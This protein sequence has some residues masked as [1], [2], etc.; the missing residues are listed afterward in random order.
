M[1]L[2]K[3]TLSWIFAV[4][5]FGLFQL[6]AVSAGT[7]D[8][9]LNYAEPIG[10]PGTDP[11]IIIARIIQI[12]L[13]FLGILA[14]S[15]IIY[16]GF[17]WMTSKGDEEK[18]S[19]AKTIL[20]NGVI[21]LVIIL[22]S[23]AIATFVLS[24]LMAAFGSGGSGSGGPGAGGGLGALGNGIIESV[25]PEPGALGVPRNTS[26]IVTFRLPMSPGSIC[27]N[28]ENDLCSPG[29]KIRT[30]SVQI[31]NTTDPNNPSEALSNVLVSSN[32]NRTFVF[33]PVEPL[34]GSQ[35]TIYT[36]MLTNEIK[37]AANQGAFGGL[38]NFSWSFEVSNEFDFMPPRIL[39]LKL[40]DNNPPI[41]ESLGIFPL[42]DN[43]RDEIS[44]EI[45]PTRAFG[46]IEA[47]N[48]TMVPDTYQAASAT[49]ERGVG[50]EPGTVGASVSGTNQCENGEVTVLI[51]TNGT[52]A[53]IS[54]T[55]PGQEGDSLLILD[56]SVPLGPCDLMVQ[57]QSG[58][59]V[60]GRS[61]IVT[62]VEERQADTLTVG[63][64]I[65]TFVNENAGNFQIQVG[66]NAQQTAVAIRDKINS[67]SN[68]HP[69]VSAALDPR[70]QTPTVIIT[71]KIAGP[72][73][74][75]L[76]LSDS[77]IA[78]ITNGMRGG[79]ERQVNYTIRGERDQPMNTIIQINFNEAINPITVAGN[80]EQL[81]N[82]LRVINA[83]SEEAFDGASC[84]MD[85]ECRSFNC[86]EGSCRGDVLSG[87]FVIA[88]QYK[89]VEFISD[90][91]C[92]VNGCGESIYCLPKDAEV[93]VE[94]EAAELY[95]CTDSSQCDQFSYTQCVNSLCQDPG[96]GQNPPR[97]NP[98]ASIINGIVD[99][100]SNSFDGN[101]NMDAE[102]RRSY[103][104]QND[105]E[106]LNRGKGDHYNWSFWVSDRLDLTPP[107]IDSV[108]VVNNQPKVHLS[109]PIKI[110]FSKLMMSSTM[111][112]GIRMVDT[113]FEQVAHRLINLWSAG[114]HL[115]GYW[116][117]SQNIDSNSSGE[118][119]KTE[120]FLEHGFFRDST[121]YNSQVGSGVKD[122]YQNCY[123]PSSGPGC[124]ATAQNPSCCRDGNGNLLA[125]A[126]L[127]ADG[128]CPIVSN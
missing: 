24:R 128:K 41:N 29:T 60:A 69:Q 61:W 94:A 13:G 47:V 17:L 91:K 96:V 110:T 105:D 100:A 113:G 86:F 88:N 32:D 11:R 3:V 81:K 124:I 68:P 117:R 82:K 35:N 89:T 120:A 48:S 127:T 51:D 122:L 57:F 64:R 118:T 80:S 73:G 59:V 102:G 25:Y 108:S 21:G 77:S 30:E 114:N 107:K 72:G 106:L 93:K 54:Y 109:L 90:K 53:N 76:E 49:I 46:A 2:F 5:F 95:A 33:R 63:S 126:T 56:N 26:I 52:H 71:A 27:L 101:R 45:E 1:S 70:A 79:N 16:A 84:S 18:V 85:N 115:V 15:L 39:G 111:T 31:R 104:S 14:V 58:E 28:V 34:G 8:L 4:L 98:Q 44:E 23:F 40:L 43:E 65:Y 99:A 9:G 55:Q 123:K 75:F 87:N 125:T 92:G 78:L 12:A 50:G 20:K 103:Y 121:V 62:T 37:T 42:P 112:T 67:T 6:A 116:V 66:A 97:N 74:N 7:P 38:N 36:V 10:L 22:S 119:D 19:K 83:Q